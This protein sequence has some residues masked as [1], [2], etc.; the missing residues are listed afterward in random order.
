[1]STVALLSRW[2]FQPLRRLKVRA[3]QQAEHMTNHPSPSKDPGGELLPLAADFPPDEIGALA[4]AFDQAQARLHDFLQRE[5]AFTRD[6]SHELRTPLTVIEG[7]LDLL[8]EDQAV[9][10]RWQRVLARC[11]VPAKP[12]GRKSMLFYC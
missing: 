1:M 9:Q 11:V 2:L 6:A 3:A 7:A 12:C 5:Q 8:S 4:A 10:Q